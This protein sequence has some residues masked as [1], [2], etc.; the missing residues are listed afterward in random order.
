MEAGSRITY[1]QWR[2]SSQTSPVVTGINAHRDRTTV[3]IYIR[4]SRSNSADPGGLSGR[5]VR[6]S[7]AL[8]CHAVQHPFPIVE[9]SEP[10]VGLISPLKHRYP[11]SPLPR[12][13]C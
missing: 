12:S 2:I 7:D 4:S 11:Q 9:K 1:G 5:R 8:W 6:D 13:D 10:Q 3:G